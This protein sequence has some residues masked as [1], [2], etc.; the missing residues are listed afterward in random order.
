MGTVQNA[1]FLENVPTFYQYVARG[2]ILLAAVL[3]DQV[4]R[5]RKR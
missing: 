1:M 5:R 3:F 2:L 4:K